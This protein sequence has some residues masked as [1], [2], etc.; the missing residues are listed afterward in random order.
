MKETPA[1]TPCRRF[2]RRAV[3]IT[4]YIIWSV[5][6]WLAKPA[7]PAEQDGRP[8]QAW[9]TSCPIAGYTSEAPGH[10]IGEAGWFSKVVGAN[11]RH[12]GH[13]CDGLLTHVVGIR[14]ILFGH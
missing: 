6:S 10:K 5:A 3:A 13:L 11:R 4:V 2:G 14:K 9:K 12:R 1:N 8:A 7:Q